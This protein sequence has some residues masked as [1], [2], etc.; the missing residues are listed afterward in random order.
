MQP[1]RLCPLNPECPP[2]RPNTPHHFH[3]LICD[4]VDHQHHLDS[5]AALSAVAEASLD[6][7]A[8]CQG[9]V[10]ITVSD[11]HTE[12]RAGQKQVW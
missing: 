6:D 7:V 8:G 12:D 1:Q 10:S 9:Q 11:M 2:L 5:R 3:E 4:V